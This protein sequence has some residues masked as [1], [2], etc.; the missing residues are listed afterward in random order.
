M[1]LTIRAFNVRPG[2]VLRAANGE[3]VVVTSVSR[4]PDSET[5]S[6]R[7]RLNE[8]DT[9]LDYC[10]RVEVVG[11]SVNEHDTDDDDFGVEF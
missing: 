11:V 7:F 4:D 5:I 3:Q 9:L 8:G 2:L 1:S 6:I 10:A